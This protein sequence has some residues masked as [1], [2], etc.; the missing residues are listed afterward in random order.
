MSGQAD[1][2][3]ALVTGA[4]GFAGA[5]VA[6]ALLGRGSRVVTIERDLPDRTS[7]ELLGLTGRVSVVPGDIRDAEAC[8][9]AIGEYEVDTVFHLAAQTIVGT[10]KR[11][12]V[13]TFDSNIRGT[14]TLLEACRIHDVARTVVA[15]SDK[16]YGAHDQLP[17]REDFA[18]QPIYPYDVSKAATDMIARSYWHTYGLP[19]AVTR[20]ANLYGGGDLNFSR[21]VPEATTAALDG[22]AP[23]IRSDGTPERD[24]LY[25]DDAAA[26]YLAIADALDGPARGHAF[27]AGGDEPHA[28]ADVVARIC[29]VAG[30]DV[31]PD[32][33]GTG[34][35]EA[36][37][38]R[39]FVDSAK[40]RELTGW[41]PQ[42]G[43]VD[44]LGRTVEWYRSHP[45]V[46]P[47]A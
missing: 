13:G 17:Y 47:Q 37:I 43:L 18:L 42:V 6:G 40:L 22:R 41:R 9:R 46:R 30:T 20:F 10:A 16:A 19:V 36:E 24:F 1:I 29:A 31:E 15:S 21:L 45:D 12:P 39:Q 14:W 34:N 4:T 32:V 27:N 26:A 44:G 35:P 7:L 8:A 5:W 11:S 3:S 23:V 38:D 25:V 2:R 28:V 33:R